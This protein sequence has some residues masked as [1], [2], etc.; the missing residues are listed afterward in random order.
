MQTVRVATINLFGEQPPLERR[1][2]LLEAGL[3]ALGADVIALQEV[4]QVPG[5]LPN[6]AETLARGLGMQCHF[7][8]ATAW[9]GGEEGLAMLSRHAII[10]RHGRELPHATAAERRVVAGVTV[11]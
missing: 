4:R 11:E 2:A 9:G 8:P 7:V 5:V 3:A 1:M 10:A 6:Q